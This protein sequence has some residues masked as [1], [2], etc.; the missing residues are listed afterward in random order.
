MET[1]IS[2]TRKMNRDYITNVNLVSMFLCRYHIC[3][4]VVA[5]S[6]SNKCEWESL[7]K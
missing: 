2:D 7:E 1:Q 4:V 5:K 3:T 6:H